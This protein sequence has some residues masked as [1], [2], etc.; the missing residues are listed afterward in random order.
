MQILLT[1]EIFHMGLFFFS[2]YKFVPALMSCLVCFLSRKVDCYYGG[3][4]KNGSLC[5]FSMSTKF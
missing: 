5:R 3:S 4:V 2:T 1:S